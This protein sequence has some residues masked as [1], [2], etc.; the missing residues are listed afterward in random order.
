MLRK[1]LVT[2]DTTGSSSSST[3]TISTCSGTTALVLLKLELTAILVQLVHSASCTMVLTAAVPAAAAAVA[4]IS[5]A[6]HQHVLYPVAFGQ[7]SS[8][9][10]HSKTLCVNERCCNSVLR[11]SCSCGTGTADS[12]LTT[13]TNTLFVVVGRTYTHFQQALWFHSHVRKL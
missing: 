4:A 11:S 1:L 8:T 3:V 7:R 5:V 9:S 2:S 13:H 6:G 10:K 12:G